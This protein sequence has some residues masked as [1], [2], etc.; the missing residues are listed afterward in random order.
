[1]NTFLQEDVFDLSAKCTNGLR[2]IWVDTTISMLQVVRAMSS[3]VVT[4]T[5]LTSDANVTV[6]L[7]ARIERMRRTVHVSYNVHNTVETHWPLGNVAMIFKSVIFLS[8][9]W[10]EFLSTA[11][12][13]VLMC[14][15]QNPNDDCHRTQMMISQHWFR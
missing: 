3:S 4:A 7:T 14:M 5:V 2:I 10:I 13:I 1:M 9:L 8:I 11:C 15:P 6:T 12:E